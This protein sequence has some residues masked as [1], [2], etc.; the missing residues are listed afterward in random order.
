MKPII[1]G[2]GAKAGVFWI[3][4]DCAVGLG[5]DRIEMDFGAIDS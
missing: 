3:S 2:Q 1:I 5:F 4:A